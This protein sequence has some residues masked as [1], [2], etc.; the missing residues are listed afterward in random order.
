MLFCSYNC[1]CFFDGI[2]DGK[3]IYRFYCV[4]IQYPGF[5]PFVR[6]FFSGH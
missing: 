2:F 6:K 3:Y 5:N 1:A 4:H